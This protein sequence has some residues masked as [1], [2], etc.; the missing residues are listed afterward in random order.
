LDVEKYEQLA[1]KPE[2][3]ELYFELQKD[4]T[5]LLEV[6]PI[7]YIYVAVPPKDGEEEGTVLV[8][9]GDLNSDEVYDIGE[10]IDGVYYKEVLV[11]LQEEGSYSEYDQIE[12]QGDIISSYV[13]IK[14][15]DGEIFAILGVDDSLVT[16]GNVQKDALQDILPIFIAIIIVVSILIMAVTCIYLYRLLLPIGFI[17]ESTFKFRG[18]GYN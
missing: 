6:S 1:S 11:K 7:T 2:E 10:T 16:I 17:R 15:A 8:D 13:P 4:L 3:G 9:G 5:Q 12:N 18:R 14:N